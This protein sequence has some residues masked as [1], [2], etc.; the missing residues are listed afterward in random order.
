MRSFRNITYNSI[1]PLLVG[2]ISLFVISGGCERLDPVKKLIVKTRSVS[3][4]THNSCSVAGEIIDFRRDSVTQHGF[5]FSQLKDPTINDATLLLGSNSKEEVFSDALTGLEA[6]ML[7]Y[8]K[9]FATDNGGTIYGDE[10]EF[11]TSEV[12][13]LTV[14][15]ITTAE[16]TT[17]TENTASS[18]G[19][20]TNN[21][22]ASI[23]QKGVC[24]GTSQNP[25]LS[26]FRT[27]DGTGSASFTSSLNGLNC[28][29]VYFVRAY[30]T[31]SEGVGYGQQL[32]FTT[33]SCT[34]DLPTL[35]TSSVTSIT[36]NSALGGG[37]VTDDG[38]ASVTAKGV[39]W[40]TSQ[41]PTIND[42]YTTDGT[43]TGSYTSSITGLACGTAYYLKAYA[44]NTSGTTYGTQVSFT[45]SQCSVNLPTVT[46]SPVNTITETSAQGGGNVTSDGGASVTAKGVCWSTSQNPTISD[47]HTTNGSGTG[48]F[49]SAITGL[50]C[51]IKYY[52]RAYVTNSVGTAYGEEVSFTT[53]ACPG[54]IPVVTTT[55]VSSITQTSAQGG[56]DVTDDGG[57]TVTAKGVCWSTSPSPTISDN[58]SSDG[59]GTGPYTSA[60]TGLSCGTTYYVRAYATNSAGTAYGTQ[61]S[62]ITGQCPSTVPTVSTI[63]LSNI[64]ETSAQGGGDVTSDGGE[65]VT[66]RG[67]CWST[68]PG[69][70][71]SDNLTTDGTGTGS[72]TSDIS[73]LNPL[74]TYYVRAYATNSLGTSYGNELNFLTS[75]E[76]ISDYDGNYYQ[77]VVIGDQTWMAENLKSIHYANG[78]AIPLVESNAMWD[79][80]SDSDKAYCWNDNNA[81]T[82]NTYGALYTW[83]TA[84]NGTGSSVANPS[85]VQG[86]CPSGWH[87]P[88]DD[89]WKQL[90]MHLG[91][92]Q[93]EAD[94][95]GWR[96][97]NEG[98]KL[99]ETG[100]T[101]WNSPN[102]GATNTSGFTALPGGNRYDYGTF[103]NVGSSALF[104]TTSEYSGSAAWAR[105]L[106]YNIAEVYRGN[107]TKS[108]GFSVRCVRDD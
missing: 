5:C 51:E 85:G 62:F 101:Y 15:S 99:K 102:I 79:G 68:S 32:S 26:N 10:L 34:A 35:S 24:W 41:N 74:T 90:E 43:G 63:S 58:N 1:I 65:T 4:I 97:T 33:N 67:V 45:T 49:T 30:A 40:S 86:V 55:V 37:D 80:L 71:T 29:T 53:G 59:T 84:M 93:T 27:T 57:R 36:E 11:T 60:I 2:S 72:F 82:G 91:M 38:G 104:W 81:S 76:L 44:T 94:K 56:G 25:T 96:G 108:N 54:G 100:T 28:N 88:S 87:L 13:V 92:I 50:S 106:S 8:V 95:E 103:F 39:C 3:D 73:G 16:I 14:P 42:S 107:Y 19:E 7:Y 6:S 64:T 83:A 70:T 48:S 66:A 31:N 75:S 98:G 46:T 9:A 69:P 20:I 52:V 23:T 77:T 78:A 47:S 18:G 17:I 105:S 22:G 12:T 89:E 21:G 61:E